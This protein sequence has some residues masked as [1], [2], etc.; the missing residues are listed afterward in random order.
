MINGT[1][2]NGGHSTTYSSAVRPGCDHQGWAL[3][4]MCLWKNW[5]IQL[6]VLVGLVLQMVLA[7]LGSR[8]KISCAKTLQ[9]VIWASYSL[10]PYILTLALSKL[11]TVSL[12]KSDEAFDT[13]LKALL[14][15]LTLLLLG[16]PDS[17]TAYSVE[18][19]RVGVRSAMNLVITF[20]FVVWILGRCWKA[21][22]RMKL[23]F[24]MFVAG[25]IK[26]GET[27]WAFYSVYDENTN[28]RK[29]DFDDEMVISFELMTKGVPRLDV[30]LTAYN[31]F[32]RLKPHLVN[33]LKYP[34]F[35]LYPSMLISEYSPDDIFLI[36]DMELEFMYDVLYTKAPVLYTKRG[37]MLRLISYFSLLLTF[38][39]FMG[40]F[41]DKLL[42]DP[43]VIYMFGLLIGVV[44]LETYQLLKLFY[45]DL[46]IIKN[47]NRLGNPMVLKFLK[48]LANR[49]LKK[50][51]WSNRIQQF[52]FLDFCQFEKWPWF[53]RILKVCGMAE[54]F[55]KYL[56]LNS[57]AIP[58]YLKEILLEDMKKFER[59]RRGL[60]FM[61]R[62][63]WTLG[64][65]ESLDKLVW[66]INMTFDRS[67]IIWHIATQVCYNSCHEE[68][69][70]KEASKLISDYMM[71]LLVQHRQILSLTTVEITY[72]QAY[73]NLKK[74][75]YQTSKENV[76]KVLLGPEPSQESGSLV[77]AV[78][79]PIR[80]NQNVLKE[81]RKLARELK[82]NKDTWELISSVWVEMLCFA[83]YNCQQKHHLKLLR[84]GGDIITH[85]WLL[86]SHSTDR[87]NTSTYVDQTIPIQ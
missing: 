50:K 60:P 46:V 61:K 42:R 54:K 63:E 24:P 37:I 10:T 34:F 16:N 49:S 15:P 87:F 78:E 26:C 62:G 72:Q 40:L 74:F 85:V 25:I 20:S 77:L 7:V 6:F 8:R 14:A 51:K 1:S 36:I 32:N 47:S 5:S 19:S 9:F 27:F 80:Q 82:D 52:N 2:T 29:E 18:D 67:I 38:G 76:P 58:M 56:A 23:F 86:L 81:V 69:D 70:R 3:G 4:M 22:I 30:F 12:N 71:F 68:S 17:I 41:F 53:F 66:S 28:M 64:I 65:H 43:Y 48:F 73:R 21:S 39:G 11:T 75:L 83:A 44:L 84:Q 35:M 45:S 33:W 57:V 59:K 13:E 55:R 31:R 79:C